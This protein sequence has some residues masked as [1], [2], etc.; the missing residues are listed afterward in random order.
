[1][2]T[3]QCDVATD[4]FRFF[5][6]SFWNRIDIAEPFKFMDS[7]RDVMRLTKVE[8]LYF[9]RLEEEGKEVGL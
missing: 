7:F 2:C 8:I 5:S 3:K 6:Q 1:M 9:S 4:R